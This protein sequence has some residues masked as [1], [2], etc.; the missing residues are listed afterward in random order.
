MQFRKD[1]RRSVVER[2]VGS[3]EIVMGHKQGGK[4]QCAI[5]AV[6][7]V[8]RFDMVLK[9]SVESFDELLVGSVGLGLSL[10]ILESDHLA[11]V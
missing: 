4:G 8:G 6:K 2:H 1:N 7:P 9:G 3:Q 10:E 5:V 11:V